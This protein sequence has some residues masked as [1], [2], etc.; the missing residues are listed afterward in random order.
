RGAE[1]ERPLPLR[2][3]AIARES[4][5]GSDLAPQRGLERSRRVGELLDWRGPRWREIH[6]ARLTFEPGQGRTDV[7]D[8]RRGDLHREIARGAIVKL[9][10]GD[11][12][13]ET[14]AERRRP[15]QRLPGPLGAYALGDPS[16][17]RKLP[18]ETARD[19]H[20]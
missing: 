9:G 20:R 18:L 19:H 13:C 15:P 8:R 5:P 1:A 12:A 4:E 14:R 16:L 10:V 2:E 3:R 17:G 6:D 7:G 11:R